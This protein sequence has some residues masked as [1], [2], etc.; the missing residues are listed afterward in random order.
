MGSVDIW[1]EVQIYSKWVQKNSVFLLPGLV[2]SQIWDL[3][4]ALTE[5]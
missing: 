4:L 3:S 1:I 2:V 5:A